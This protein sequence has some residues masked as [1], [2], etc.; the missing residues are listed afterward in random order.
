MFPDRVDGAGNPEVEDKPVTI[1]MT[2]KLRTGE[3]LAGGR[4]MGEYGERR[5]KKEDW[6]FKEL[7]YLIDDVH[8]R[9]VNR[10]TAHLSQ[11]TALRFNRSQVEA[12]WS[13]PNSSQDRETVKLSLI[14]LRTEG[15][16]IRNSVSKI[17][18]SGTS[19]FERWLKEVDGW[20]NE[21]IETI[22]KI[23]AADSEWFKTLDAVPS[24]RVQMPNVRLGKEMLDTCC[25]IYSQ[26][27]Y[28]L[29]RLEKLLNKYGVAA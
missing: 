24:P 26:H 14:K 20:K 4:H 2:K 3:L 16:A 8:T 17:Y 5:L 18:Y 27:D 13:Q 22:E 1:A 7:L 12:L 11:L 9:P 23:D 6:E 25:R 29:V 28:R 21:V 10:E 15:V 19:D